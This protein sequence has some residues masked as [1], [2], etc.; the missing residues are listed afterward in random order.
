MTMGLLFDL[1]QPELERYRPEVAEPADFVDF[2][3]KELADARAIPLDATF[4]PVDTAL[5]HAE[6]YDVSYAGH[7]G[8]TIKGWLFV[9]H[10][11]APNPAVV[12]EFIGYGGGRGLPVEWLSFSCAGHPHLV[13]DTRGQG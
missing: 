11:L 5:R 6:V 1:P 8:E 12:V 13:M 9:P 4:T 3:R 2:W 10:R 7:G